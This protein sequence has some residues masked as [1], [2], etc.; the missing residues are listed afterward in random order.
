MKLTLL[1]P[2]VRPCFRSLGSAALLV[3]L[4]AAAPAAHA[5]LNP[6]PLNPAPLG[7][8]DTIRLKSGVRYWTTQ[9]GTGERP[10]A[11]QKVWIH[12]TGRLADGKIFDTSSL[13]GK[14]L[15]FTVGAQQVIPGMD[16]MVAL[17]RVGQRV[18][19][20]LPAQLGYGPVGQP[21]DTA[22]EGQNA[23]RIP[24]NADLTFDLELVKVAK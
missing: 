8:V 1:P 9:A 24:P 19:C 23:Y 20:V 15:K 14:P 17:M 2:T 22:E 11:G 13:T 3:A 6:T 16:E 12:Y 5:Q 18:T 7:P 10:A 21:D 4:L